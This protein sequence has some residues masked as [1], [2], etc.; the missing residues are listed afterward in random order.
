EP[1]EVVLPKGEE[2]VDIRPLYNSA[3]SDDARQAAVEAMLTRGFAFLNE[4][5]RD[6]VSR[7]H[8]LAGY[9]PQ[10]FKQIGAV[11]GVTEAA[12]GYC[13]RRALAKLRRAL[14]TDYGQLTGQALEGYYTASQAAAVLDMNINTFTRLA[15][16][17]HL[18]RVPFGQGCMSHY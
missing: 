4:R 6:V 5:Q 1:L 7:Y 14:A 2:R 18:T 12:A 11:Y 16:S 15:R 10:T 8:G 9:E 13:Y 3:A 17:G